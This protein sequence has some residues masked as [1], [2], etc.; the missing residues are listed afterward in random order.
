MVDRYR[1]HSS[2][3]GWDQEAPGP[4]LTHPSPS[5]AGEPGSGLHHCPELSAPPPWGLHRKASGLGDTG[6]VP[7]PP[8][9][10][11]G[12]RVA[13]GEGLGCLPSGACVFPK[14]RLLPHGAD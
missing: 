3:T 9:Q 4:V 12:R 14:P 11:T 13:G 6:R 1:P 5:D 2:A 10:C 7:R 8:P